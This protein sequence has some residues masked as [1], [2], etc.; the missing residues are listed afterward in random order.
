MKQQPTF[1]TGHLADTMIS[2]MRREKV[3]RRKL[4]DYDSDDSDTSIKRYNNPGSMV[5][6]YMRPMGPKP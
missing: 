1:G 5:P 4:G 2:K 6:S 3:E